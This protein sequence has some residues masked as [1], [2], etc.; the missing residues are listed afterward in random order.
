MK[1]KIINFFKLLIPDAIARRLLNGISPLASIGKNCYLYKTQIGDFSYLAT[2][3]TVMNTTIGKFCSIGQ[4]VA[5]SLGMHPSS[6]FVSTHP[7]FF[8]PHK[9][10]GISFTTT[11][12]FREMG[13]S[14]IGNDV[15]IGANAIIMD[16]ITIGD[17]AIIGA[18]AIVTRNVPAYAI[19]VGNPAKI[20][21]YRFKEEEIEF[22]LK[23]KWW[24]KELSWLKE[25]YML[26]HD[27]K[28]FMQQ[29]S[30]HL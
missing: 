3:V 25:N 12:Q 11:S 16:D 14:T 21:R 6:V 22:L 30:S 7:A 8:S 5:I 18:G 10:A 27:I 17:G 4:G 28:L 9:Q 19:V 24:D 13:Q 15:W 1:R 26:F 2:G 23:F 29:F 20:L